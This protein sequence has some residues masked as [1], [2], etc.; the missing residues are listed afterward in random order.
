MSLHYR[1]PIAGFQTEDANGRYSLRIPQLQ[2]SARGVTW[3]AEEAI[4]DFEEVFVATNA[5]DLAMINAKLALGRHVILAPGIY[6]LPAPIR[7][8]FNSSARQQVLLGLGM[9]TLVPTNGNS[10]VEIG[11]ATGVRGSRTLASSRSDPFKAVAVV[12]AFQWQPEQSWTY[13]RCFCTSW[14]T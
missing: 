11:A 1:C 4:V 7:V 8:G 3:N 10:V 14:W 13:C 5:T 6:H 12:E 9:A 2:R